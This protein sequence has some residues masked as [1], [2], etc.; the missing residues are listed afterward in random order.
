ME[1]VSRARIRASARVQLEKTPLAVINNKELVDLGVFLFEIVKLHTQLLELLLLNVLLQLRL[2]PFH[3]LI[4]NNL[5]ERPDFV[6]NLLALSVKL[7]NLRLMLLHFLPQT[8]LLV[9]ELLHLQ[10][11]PPHLILNALHLG[12]R[13]LQFCL[14]LLDLLANLQL[15]FQ[16]SSLLGLELLHLLLCLLKLSLQ[17]E[18]LFFCLVQILVGDLLQATIHFCQLYLLLPYSNLELLDFKL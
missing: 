15:F 9:L 17:P 4:L 1:Q 7:R 8:C 12:F 10:S 5:F 2:L 13:F 3:F 6:L 14:L 18:V 11:R 16:L